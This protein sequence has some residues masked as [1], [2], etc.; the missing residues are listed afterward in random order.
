MEEDEA[1]CSHEQVAFFIF[2]YIRII[3]YIEAN[4]KN[5]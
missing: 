4:N 5:I 2:N 1:T 3:H